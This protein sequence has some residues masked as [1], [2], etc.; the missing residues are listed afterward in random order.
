MQESK[1][2]TKILISVKGQ[3][4][5]LVPKSQLVEENSSPFFFFLQTTLAPSDMIIST[6]RYSSGDRS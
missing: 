6:V 4:M 3:T 1:P 5:K 2:K